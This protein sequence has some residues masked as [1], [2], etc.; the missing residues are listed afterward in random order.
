MVKK[1][2]RFLIISIIVTFL[3]SLVAPLSFAQDDGVIDF[4]TV[5][6]K[7]DVNKNRV[8]NSIYNWSIYMP[9]D[10]YINKD[11]KGS[12]FSM[13]SSSYKANISVEAIPNKE[14]FSSLDEILLYGSDIINSDGSVSKIYSLKKGK[15]KNGQEYIEITSVYTDSFYVFVDEEE[16][17]GT[18]NLTRIYL[19]KNKKYNY[20][21]RLTISMDLNFYTEHKNLLYKIADSFEL[22]FD[23]K[24]PNIKD[25]ADNVTS[26]RVHKNTS[27][28]WQIDLPPY[29]KS[30]DIYN[31][32]Y[33]SST[34]SFA[35]LYTDEEIGLNT[36]KQ[37]DGVTTPL[38]VEQQEYDEYLSVS[39]VANSNVSFDKWVELEMKNVELYNKSLCKIISSKS[40]NI[41][42]AKA[43]L[44]E[45]NI[46]KS[47]QKN[48]VEK[49]MYVDFNN[50]KYFVKLY[51]KEDK[52]NKDKQKYDRIINSFKPIPTKSK[53]LDSILW[54][55]DLKPQN[56]FKTVK[57]NKAP[58]EMNISKDYKTNI[59]Y[60]YYSYYTQVINA[61]TLS[62]SQGISD[63][64]TITL[65]NTP[66]STLTIN[67][68]INLDPAEKIIKNTMQAWVE[69]NEYKSKTADMKLQKYST[70]ELTIYKF[71]Y[72]YNLSKLPDLAKGNPNRDFNFL[73]LQN[74]VIY[75]I[76]YKQYY[77]TIDL[78][79]PVL[80]WNS[81]T[82]DNFTNS[83]NTIKIDKVN[84]SKLNMKF[85]N[86][87]LEK[88]KKKDNE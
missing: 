18:F 9:Q 6:S 26:W 48:F 51:V 13:S 30:T 3:L 29:W 19:S 62:I 7:D 59:P 75:M 66:Y 23:S 64:E 72:V 81:I 1:L 79:V 74:R 39:F 55:G 35:P 77:Y 4:Y 37:Q 70:G 24:N 17:S 10:A 78:S 86:E 14:S 2:K 68:G 63:V 73:N 76:K 25:L 85:V 84:F 20:I 47:L 71:T 12:Y 36:Q 28:G 57:L 67:G 54:T 16:T 40:L 44:F 69:S 38:Q 11:P 41:N 21:Y 15:D 33:N 56:T 87:D 49:R 53:Y 88:F 8:G 31:F 52:Y 80:Y 32:E 65:Y 50:N 27:Y 83:I 42:G 46:R 60:Y 34:Q 43:K 5:F 45:L 58:F 82:L 61:P 22:Q